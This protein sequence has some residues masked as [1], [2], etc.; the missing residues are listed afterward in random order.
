[1]QFLRSSAMAW[2]RLQLRQIPNSPTGALYRS[3]ELPKDWTELY[4][5]R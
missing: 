4:A 3:S 1:M 5:R 2:D